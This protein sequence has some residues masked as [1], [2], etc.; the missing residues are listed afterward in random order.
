MSEAC[1]RE[2]AAGARRVLDADLGLAVT[3]AAGPQEH[4]GMPVGTVWVAL[5]AGDATHA[6]RG[7]SAGGPRDGATAHRARG[8]RSR[9]DDGSRGS[10]SRR[11]TSR[12]E[13]WPRNRASRPEARSLR[14]F[15]A[16]EI[17]SEAKRAVEVAVA[18]WRPAFATA[19]WVPT[20]N[21]HV[22]V[23]FLGQTWPRLRAWVEERVG[24]TAASCGAVRH[25]SRRCRDVPVAAPGTGDLGRARR[26]DRWHGA[27]RPRARRRS[28]RR[29][30]T[31]STRVHAAPHGRPERPAAGGAGVVRGDHRGSGGVPCRSGRPLPQPSTATGA[32]L[33]ARRDVRPGWMTAVLVSEHLFG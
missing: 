30:P 9:C 3:G 4:G 26:R 2:M 20:E 7:A 14:L 12:A 5:D 21:W 27:G 28:R 15:V 18:P 22:T 33:R 1:A 19:R 6:R 16:I 17:P 24:E 29:V 13:R 23:K 25:T 10:R 31:G 32:R 11:P 8:A